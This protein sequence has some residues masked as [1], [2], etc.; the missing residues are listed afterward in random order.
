MNML[1]K[2]TIVA[3][4]VEMMKA[5]CPDQLVVLII[6]K[7]Q[8]HILSVTITSKRHVDEEVV[9]VKEVVARNH[10]RKNPVALPKKITDRPSLLYR[11]T[12]GG[13]QHRS[14]RASA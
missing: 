11:I 6:Q 2:R 12:R 9:D 4:I 8:E 5:T 14:Y 7:Q 3:R 10:R 1:I 13:V